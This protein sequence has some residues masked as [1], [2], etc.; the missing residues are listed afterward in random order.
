VHRHTVKIGKMKITRASHVE[1]LRAHLRAAAEQDSAAGAAE[2]SSPL[3][4]APML[5]VL[6]DA[7]TT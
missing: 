5:G 7:T 4:P 2:P 3:E 1:P 6:T